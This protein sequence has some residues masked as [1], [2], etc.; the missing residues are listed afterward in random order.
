MSLFSRRKLSEYEPNDHQYQLNKLNFKV[1]KL[2]D[3]IDKL[4]NDWECASQ[5]E[6]FQP[7]NGIDA[8][9]AANRVE[10]AAQKALPNELKN[11]FDEIN[12]AVKNEQQSVRLYQYERRACI[13]TIGK[14]QQ[15]RIYH[16]EALSKEL[17]KYGYETKL[18]SNGLYSFLEVSWEGKGTS[19]A[20]KIDSSKKYILP[21]EG[22]E[23]EILDSAT[24]K[25]IDHETAFAYPRDG[26]WSVIHDRSI[27]SDAVVVPGKEIVDAP[28]WVQAIDPIVAD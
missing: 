16:I 22:T 8:K 14:P 25:V 20:S 28:K 15:K 21:L 17:K 24:G 13:N 1:T 6:S 19:N 23:E 5:G 9:E 12:L 3:R 2:E 11:A 4:E 7:A 27:F 26:K 18:D 10:K